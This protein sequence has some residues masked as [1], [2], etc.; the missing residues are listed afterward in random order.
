MEKGKELPS[1]PGG[2]A[3]AVHMLYGGSIS[4]AYAQILLTLPDVDGLGGWR[5]RRDPDTLAEIVC[6]IARARASGS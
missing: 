5:K 4:P 2:V 3:Q 6:L 1:G